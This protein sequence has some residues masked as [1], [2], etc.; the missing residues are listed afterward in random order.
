[1]KLTIAQLKGRIKSLAQKNNA[2][3]RVLMRMYMMERFLERVASSQYRD[4]FIIKGGI[5]VTNMIGVAL[6]STM[7]IDASI[8]NESLTEEHLLDMISSICEIN[9]DD[10]VSFRVKK[11]SKS[12]MKWSIPA[13]VSRWTQLSDKCPFL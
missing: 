3:P 11:H 10:D 2:D 6:R 9:L 7:D 13:Y 5:L 1:M 4:H 12:W 8:K